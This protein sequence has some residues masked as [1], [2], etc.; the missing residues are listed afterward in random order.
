[1]GKKVL[2]GM[3]GGVDSSVSAVLLIE[4]GYEVIGC[5][6]RLTKG[7]NTDACGNESRAEG[8]KKICD[9]LGIPHYTFDFTAEFSDKVISNFINEYRLCRTPNP[10]IVCNKYLKFGKMFEKR[11][12]LGC[13][14]MS[15]GHYA[16]TEYSE[17]YGSVVLKKARN[18]QKDQTY[19]LYNMT[20]EIAE[21]LIF[22]LEEF[23]SK[24]RV[25]Q[26]AAEH[27]M[28]VAT[29]PD[30]ED[31]CFIPDG[32]YKK[33]LEENSDIKPMPGDAVLTD[34]TVVG[35]H[36][37]LYRYTIGQRKGLGI[38][39]K[40]PIYVVGFDTDANRLIMGA[41][42]DLYSDRFT[43]EKVNWILKNPPTE[44]IKCKV[45]TR[46]SQ[47]EYD[48]TVFPNGAECR[49]VFDR[50]QKSVTPGQ[51]AVFYDGDICL[52][53]GVIK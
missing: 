1:M 48:C 40:H 21:R 49:V 37:G 26:V 13:D 7:S 12:E 46:Y 53:G 30:S 11:R 31:A 45:K 20:A 18:L 15:T 42:S 36:E 38:A 51:S 33:F 4:K 41:E 32:D 5:T 24:D 50:P 47:R 44:A 25:R 16:R 23:E 8:A 10:C 29:K 22:P 52:G 17:K 34:G 43:A 2:L 27:G 6:M 9:E 35:R 39:Y 3:S 28:A 19:F 14:Y